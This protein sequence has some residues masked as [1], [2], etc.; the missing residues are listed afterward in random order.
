MLN[1]LP[2]SH[3]GKTLFVEVDPRHILSVK[4]DHGAYF[5]EIIIKCGYR[6]HHTKLC[7]ESLSTT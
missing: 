4:K 3:L 7:S 6:H 1:Y 2:M 5:E